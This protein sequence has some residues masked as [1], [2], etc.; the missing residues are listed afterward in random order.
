MR[1]Y[2][3]LILLAVVYVSCEEVSKIYVPY[4]G[5]KIVLNSFLQPDSLIYIRVTQSKQIRDS[6]SLTFPELQNAVITLSENGVALPTPRWKVI[7]GRGFFVSAAPAQL[8]KN[9]RITVTAR[10]LDAVAAADST[11][12]RP[13]ISNTRAQ[14]NV[15][16][17]KFTLKDDPAVK[18]YYR[19]RFFRG[20]LIN[21]TM[22]RNTTDTIRCRVD[23]A[24][25][26]NLIDMLGDT[27]F[28]DI[29]ITDRLFTSA[30]STFTLQTQSALVSGGFVII[31]VS[32]LT[33]GA[34]KYLQATSDQRQGQ[35]GIDFALD[36]VN[37]YS[38]VENGYGIVAG[39]NAVSLSVSVE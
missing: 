12:W 31:E 22:V 3:L 29:V 36:P 7:N 19:I 8:G 20:D 14:S 1:I 17:I 18:N 9:Y 23:P 6:G 13:D 21:G 15:N 11:P 32:G 38:N 5:D 27:Y 34:Y 37:V 33:E 39:I 30:E 26:N 24:F 28:S 10:D 25:S 16:R 35:E 4:D 2:V